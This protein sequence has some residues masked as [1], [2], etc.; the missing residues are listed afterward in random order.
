[1]IA[2]LR[3]AVLCK[4]TPLSLEFDRNEAA[5]ATIMQLDIQIGKLS[6][7]RPYLNHLKTLAISARVRSVDQ[8]SSEACSSC[9]PDCQLWDAGHPAARALHRCAR[10]SI[11]SS[12]RSRIDGGYGK[13]ER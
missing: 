7:A 12:A 6:E 2:S 11:I 4:R 9:M 13:A 1:M 5:P 3:L 8:K 10:Y